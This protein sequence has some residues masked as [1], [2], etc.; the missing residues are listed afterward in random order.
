MN[1]LNGRSALV[2]GGA[3][4]IGAA[5]AREL[6]G[7]GARVTVADVNDVAAKELASEIGGDVWSVD[8]LDT[9]ALDDLRLDVDILVNNAGI[10]TVAPIVDFDPGAFRRIQTLMVEA[11]FLLVRAALP[12]MYSR[13][14]GRV[15]NLSSVHG[16]RASEFKVA[17]VTA[18]HALEGLSKVTAL[19]GAAH[20]VTSNCVNPGYVRTPLVETQIADQAKAHGI[21]ENE[22]LEKV[23]LTEAAIKRLVEPAEVASLVGWL[24]SENAGMVTGASYTMDGGWSAR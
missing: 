4:G 15:V 8:L 14:F 7:R 19:E 10:Q 6:A 2:T 22:V 3:S 11:P 24:T 20:G 9:T 16:L 13:G 1:D 17:Y 23:L 5:C 21:P 18:K 12:H